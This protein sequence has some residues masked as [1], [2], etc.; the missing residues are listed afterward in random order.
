LGRLLSDVLELEAELARPARTLALRLTE[1]VPGLV[2]RLERGLKHRLELAALDEASPHLRDDRHLLDADRADL[3]ARH[4]LR[5]RPDRLRSDPLADLRVG[6]RVPRQL[7]QVED[8]V[9]R[10]ERVA[11]GVRRTG[12][13]TLAALRARVER[14]EMLPCEVAHPAVAD[15]LGRRLRR[16]ERQSLAGAV[17]AH[18]DGRRSREH[19]YRLRERDPRAER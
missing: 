13:V 9:A 7:A 12:D 3:D 10:R 17:V 16:E 11:G 15:L 1:R 5:A 8:D 18:A 4:A 6:S 2:D 14:D 19:V